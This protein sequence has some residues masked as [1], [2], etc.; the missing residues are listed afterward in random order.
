MLLETF[1]S[2][3]H[4]YSQFLIHHAL[5]DDTES[6]VTVCTFKAFHLNFPNVLVA[7]LTVLRDAA[8]GTVNGTGISE[9]AV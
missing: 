1:P 9:K 5:F 4:I 7:Y 2:A 6:L 8:V 3:V